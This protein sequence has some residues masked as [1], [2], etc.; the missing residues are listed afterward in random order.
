MD[1]VSG[2]NT[3]TT[4]L[5]NDVTFTGSWE[6]I[7]EVKEI[8]IYVRASHAGTL[9]CQFNHRA[10][11]TGAKT[12]AYTIGGGSKAYALKPLSSFFRLT[13][14]NGATTQT[15]FVLTTIFKNAATSGDVSSSS[16]L[17]AGEENAMISVFGERVVVVPH[18]MLKLI[19]AYGINNYLADTITRNTATATV[20]GGLLRL[21]TGATTDSICTATSRK[22]FDYLAGLGVDAR[23]TAIFTTGV[24]NSSQI[25]G[26]GSEG[27]G[28]FFGY[29]G[30]TFGVLRRTGGNPEVRTL[31]I[32][33][34]ATTAGG[35]ITITLNGGA[36][37]V[38]AIANGDS[39]T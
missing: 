12:I 5:A 35:N 18:I 4:L 21:Q 23:F 9:N 34:G 20:T 8:I 30:A 39:I 14:V 10:S 33:N 29:N 16:S 38:V 31:T 26:V 15:T 2:G 37:V 25:I 6:S 24:A 17:S 13:Y 32:T 3:T 1:R 22:T 11:T 19:F 28:F 7:V 27:A 36:G